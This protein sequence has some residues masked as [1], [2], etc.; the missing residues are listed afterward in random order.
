MD[1]P[2][3]FRKG[4]IFLYGPIQVVRHTLRGGAA[5][6]LALLLC[7]AVPAGAADLTADGRTQSVSA[8]ALDPVGHTVGIKLFA[9][10]V[11]VVKMPEGRDAPPGAA[12]CRPAT[13]SSDAAAPPSPPREQF[14]SLLQENGEAA[15]DLQVRREGTSVTLSVLPGAE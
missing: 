2:A 12:A 14:R 7:A 8:R 10:G 11:M 13:S 3:A 1:L 4:V 6:V 9:R 15:T 5:L